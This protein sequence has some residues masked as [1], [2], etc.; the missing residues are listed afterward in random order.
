M[1]QSTTWVFVALGEGLGILPNPP[2]LSRALSV[3]TADPGLLTSTSA[4]GGARPPAGLA[5]D[6]QSA[7][8]GSTEPRSFLMWPAVLSPLCLC[9]FIHL[10][11]GGCPEPL[12]PEAGWGGCCRQ[13][14]GV[15]GFLSDL[16]RKEA[17]TPKA[18]CDPHPRP[19]WRPCLR[20]PRLLSAAILWVF[21]I[22]LS[23]ARCV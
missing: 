9:R 1:G 7:P 5:A 10:H 14:S 16:L 23:W 2:L 21:I 20:H 13:V 17:T 6:W 4:A 3:L 11:T 18:P 12:V 22:A 19:Q 8:H 15:H